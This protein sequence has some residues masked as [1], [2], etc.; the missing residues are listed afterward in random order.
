MTSIDSGS[1]PGRTRFLVVAD[2]VRAP[3][4]EGIQLHSTLPLGGWLEVQSP[5]GEL[6]NGSC[7]RARMLC[8]FIRSFKL[9]NAFRRRTDSWSARAISSY[10]TDRRGRRRYSAVVMDWD[11]SRRKQPVQ[12]HR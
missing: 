3:R 12:W 4:T 1:S 8:G 2:E 5:M 6:G 10:E 11:R 7:S 9:S